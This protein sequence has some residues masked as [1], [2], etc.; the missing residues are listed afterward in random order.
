MFQLA[1][2]PD[3][4]SQTTLS[5][6]NEHVRAALDALTALTVQTEPTTRRTQASTPSMSPSKSPAK[7]PK[8]YGVRNGKEGN[9]V[10][11]SWAEAGEATH[12]PN[13]IHKSFS[14]REEAEQ[15]I[16]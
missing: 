2:M 5:S 7:G 1:N 11:D 10:Y 16:A 9:R 15:F 3:N 14:S 13:C 12:S 8:F 6:S 4:C